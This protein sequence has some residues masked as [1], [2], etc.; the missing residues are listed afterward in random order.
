MTADGRLPI[1]L[2]GV[3]DGFLRLLHMFGINVSWPSWLPYPGGL[4]VVP[5]DSLV[6]ILIM[7]LVGAAILGNFLPHSTWFNSAVNVSALFVGGIVANAIFSL[8]GI[9]FLDSTLAAALV[10]NVGMTI[11][12][13]GVLVAYRNAS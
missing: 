2:R 11:V 9:H 13:L 1:V 3:M 7:S 8:T 4:D 6:L 10:A 5:D 12:G